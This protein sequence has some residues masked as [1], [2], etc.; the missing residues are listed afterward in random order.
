MPSDQLIIE[1]QMNLEPVDTSVWG[2]IA[3]IT[4]IGPLTDHHK[5][6]LHLFIYLGFYVAFNTV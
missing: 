3:D 6:G 4:L 1:Q 2:E 5:D